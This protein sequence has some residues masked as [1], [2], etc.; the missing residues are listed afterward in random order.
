MTHTINLSEEKTSCYR[1]NLQFPHMRA[2]HF[3]WFS[4]MIAFMAWY[5]IPPIV[6][7]IAED[8][9]ISS[10]EIYDSNMVAV[11]ITIVARLVVGPLCERF[12]PRRVMCVILICGAIPCG[13]TALITNGAGLIGVRAVIGIL[14]AA[15]VPCQ[16]WTTQ[17]FA[18]SIVGTA[19][20]ISAGWGNM[21]AGVTYLLMPAIYDGI[22]SHTTNAIAWRMTF[23]V[24][25]GI[26]L[27]VAAMNYFLATDT[28][29]GDWFVVKN[30]QD[31][32]EFI[33]SSISV[34]AS[35]E[36]P[37]QKLEKALSNNTGSTSDG[38]D[39]SIGEVKRN[40]SFKGTLFSF[41]MVLCKPA[42]LVM[43][44]HYACSLGTELAI[45]NVIGQVFREKFALDNSTSSYIGSVFG[46]LNVCS[47]LCG[48]LFSD[49][50]AQQF[51][52]PGR[53]L[54]HFILMC[55]EGVF[56]IGFSFGLI[57]LSSAIVLMILFS[58]FVQAV[59]GSTFGIVPFVDPPNNGKVMGLVGAAGNVGGLVFNLM[60][61][62]LQPDFEKA[63]LCLGCISLGAGL[64]GNVI[65]RVQGKTIWHLFGD[66]YA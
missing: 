3:A 41:G 36:E 23:V 61:R 55:L 13:L 21:G 20:S 37:E 28:P 17:M 16:F 50:M 54:A 65:I 2:L 25:A 35:F 63:F 40:Q 47:R 32:Q 60:F 19:N 43:M 5:A 62:Q 22:V 48:G 52:I 24:P 1:K 15:F 26:C 38:D 39:E 66:N 46:L 51:H 44:T 33:S 18:P 27:M 56:L 29:Q 45:D 4:F 31:T 11:A 57:S 6:Y 8:L 58:F 9:G 14:G 64:I 10:V 49:F 53:I 7:H 30:N 12:G 59:C 42:V 34:A